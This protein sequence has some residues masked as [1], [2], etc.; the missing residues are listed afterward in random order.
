LSAVIAAG[1]GVDNDF[2]HVLDDDDDDDVYITNIEYG[3]LK[4]LY[5]IRTSQN[6]ISIK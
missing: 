4:N 2:V 5:S 3:M 1:H 6:G